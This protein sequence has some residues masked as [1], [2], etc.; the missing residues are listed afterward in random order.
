MKIILDGG[1]THMGK[2][3][4]AK[5]LIDIAE[6]SGADY[7]KFQLFPATKE[8]KEAGN[9]PLKHDMF[10]ELWQYAANKRIGLTA[11]VFSK[12]DLDFLISFS[13]PFVKFSHSQ[14]KQGSWIQGCLTSGHQVVV[15]TDHSGLANLR[16]HPSL[17]R[18]FCVPRY[19]VDEVLHFEGKFPP[20]DGFSDHTVGYEQTLQAAARGAE[21]IEKHITLEYADVTCPDATY[22]HSLTAKEV[23]KMVK[24]LREIR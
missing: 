23:K 1:S 14:S 6:D 4:Y 11:S 7:I 8:Q 16:T 15:S 21:W 12:D 3:A 19:P 17:V 20:F 13:V 2:L 18:L 10:K 9:V 5:E 24:E 22:G